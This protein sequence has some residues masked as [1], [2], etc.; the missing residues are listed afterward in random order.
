MRIRLSR[1]A[2]DIGGVAI[3]YILAI[4]TDFSIY[5][6]ENACEE[7]RE[8]KGVVQ[9]RSPMRSRRICLARFVGGARDSLGAR[10][11]Q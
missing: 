10:Q 9:L 7:Y 3:V 4:V 6:F 5:R 1:V 11:V 2:V 8:S